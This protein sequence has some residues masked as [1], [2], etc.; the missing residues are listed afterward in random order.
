M[1][2][3]EIKKL[4]L[5]WSEKVKE[6]ANNICESCHKFSKLEAAHII[7]R[8]HRTTRL[9][10]VFG[11][12]DGPEYDIAGMALCHYCHRQYDQHMPLERVIRRDVVGLQRYEILAQSANIIAK[13]QSFE[14]IKGILENL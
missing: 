11:G 4:D 9:G 10:C 12:K 7:G 3:K 8:S 2:K 5:L 6:R 14:E 1:L 13:N